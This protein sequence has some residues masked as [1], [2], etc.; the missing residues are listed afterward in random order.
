MKVKKARGKAALMLATMLVVLSGCGGNSGNNANNTA[1]TN[2]PATTE[3]EN[4]TTEATNNSTATDETAANA[5]AEN[6]KAPITFKVQVNSTTKDFESTDVY[7][8]ITKQTGVTMDLETF[9]EEKFKVELAGGDL[10]DIIQVKN[11]NTSYLKQL[12]EGNNIIPLDDL[13]VSNG[14]DIQKPVFEKSLAYSKK[15]WSNDTGKLYVIPVQIGQK[16][17]GFE[18]GTGFVVR[19]DY[20]KE[21]GFPQVKSIDDMVNVLADM[22]AKHPKTADGKKV[23]GTSLW[24]DWG[25]WGL[26]SMGMLTGSGDPIVND[27][28]DLA[29]SG[30]WANAEFLYKSKQKGILDP[31]AFTAKYEDLVTKASQGTLLNAIATWP[32]QNANAEL[33]KEGPD[34][35]FVTLPLDWGFAWAAGT[36][37][38]GWGDR[39]WAIT[40]NC[41]DPARAM[42]LI[43]FLSSEQ[44]SR[45]IESGIQGVHWDMVDGKPQM[46]PEIVELSKAGGDPWKKTGIN[47]M[48]N[49]QGL[50]DDTMLSDG[51]PVNLFNTPEVFTTKMN[52]LQK[53]YA[54]HFGVPYPA[55]AY[56][57]FEDAGSVKTLNVMPQDEQAAMAPLTDDMKRIQTKLD[58]L[59]TKGI[60]DIVLH[61]KNEEDYK[62]RQQKLID[63]LNDAGAEEFYQWRLK[64]FDEAKAK[65]E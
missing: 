47:M 62:A 35:G 52:S 34:K 31:D 42:D 50:S 12:I 23:Y 20:Y 53:D 51:G 61:A 21:L 26:T 43:N 11:I 28:T 17:W 38:A 1:S 22:V 30:V 15:F 57:K 4:T 36:T 29:K 58:D 14:P 13:V 55:A 46:K 39:A 32:F 65:F 40:S 64:A 9:D 19:W 49:Q 45:L 44:G 10:P 2:T 5:P 59:I 16:G 25:T 41:K 24:N 8:E 3:T 27:Y 63:K 18:Q 56:S 54:D 60:P 48:A 6:A 37:V 7:A 33:L